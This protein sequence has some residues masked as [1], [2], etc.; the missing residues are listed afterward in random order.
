MAG[1]PWKGLTVHTGGP[2]RLFL[3][4]VA[5]LLRGRRHRL[6]DFPEDQDG[7]EAE[8][9]GNDRGAAQPA[10]QRPPGA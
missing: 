6:W 1:H 10:L 2:Q 5:V 7:G 4:Q 8:G 3:L 9:R